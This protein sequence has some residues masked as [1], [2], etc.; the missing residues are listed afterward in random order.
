V[1]AWTITRSSR[2]RRRYNFKM[3]WS[4]AA[5]LVLLFHAAYV[6]YV[7]LGLGAILL[8]VVLN[9]DWVRNFWFRATH[10]AAIGLVAAESIVGVT[11]PLT[12]LESRLRIA[13]GERGYQAGCIA[14]WVAPL[15][16]FDFPQWVFTIGYV[17]FATIV[18][19][20]FWVAPPDLTRRRGAGDVQAGP[21]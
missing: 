12:T 7:V 16:F 9:W 2:K 13:A 21:R 1:R 14:H 15:I 8:G 17:A 6:A 18:A 19:A 11:C 10:L 20:V 3:R 4:W 5:D